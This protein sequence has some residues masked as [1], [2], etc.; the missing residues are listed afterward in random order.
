MA[1]EAHDSSK[2]V[3]TMMATTD[4]VLREDPIYKEISKRFQ[5]N[6]G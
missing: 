1:P 5:E 3:P 2:K 6:P 4:I